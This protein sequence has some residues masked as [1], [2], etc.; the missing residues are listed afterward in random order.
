VH[1]LPL[2]SQMVVQKCK[3][4]RIANKTGL[5]L[6]LFNWQSMSSSVLHAIEWLFVNIVSVISFNLHVNELFV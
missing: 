3:L 2:V 5:K 1:L 4:H 6:L